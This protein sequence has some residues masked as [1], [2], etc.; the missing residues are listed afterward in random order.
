MMQ[1]HF[2]IKSFISLIF[3]TALAV[4]SMEVIQKVSDAIVT[5][6]AKY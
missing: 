3:L 4:F 2:T 1:Q 5:D 6:L